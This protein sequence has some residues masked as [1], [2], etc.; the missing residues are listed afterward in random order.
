[1]TASLT[2]AEIYVHL[3]RTVRGYIT[4]L[5]T[6]TDDQFI[7]KSADEVWSLG[8]MYE[9]L[10][11]TSHYFFFANIL[12][13]FEHRKGQLGGE[14]N[15]YGDNI[16]KYNSF[17]PVKVKIPEPLRG[18]EPVAKTREEY[19]VLLEKVITD[20]QKLIEPLTND[21]GEYK[22]F[23]PVFAWLNAHEWYHNMEMHFRHHLRQQK[24]LEALAVA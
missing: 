2:P 19:R 7:F 1:M 22:C 24:E 15:Q 20:A 14:R 4:A 3:E 8:Q 16:F 5:D 23:H 9:H 12:R 10:Y 17:P 11:I 13:C 18:P 6:Y 21:A